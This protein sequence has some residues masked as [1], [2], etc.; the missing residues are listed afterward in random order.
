MWS[1]EICYGY[2]GY[3][4][5]D[6]LYW[7]VLS[8]SGFRQLPLCYNQKYEF[9]E[10]KL[11]IFPFINV[12]RGW[13]RGGGVSFAVFFT[14]IISNIVEYSSNYKSRQVF[15]KTFCHKKDIFMNSRVNAILVYVS[16]CVCVCV[17]SGTKSER[18]STFTQIIKMF[19]AH[20]YPH[21]DDGLSSFPST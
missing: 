4:I 8:C 20:H 21:N 18:P 12:Q 9:N 15:Y 19:T 6:A 5:Y 2:E 14:I 10:I 17:F 7:R 3:A 1:L 16:M 11:P 13:E